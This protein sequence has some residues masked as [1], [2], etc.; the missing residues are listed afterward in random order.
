[1]ITIFT[2][3]AAARRGKE[4]DEAI[5]IRIAIMDPFRNLAASD[6]RASN[7]WPPLQPS[8][9][10]GGGPAGLIFRALDTEAADSILAGMF[11]GSRMDLPLN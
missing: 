6:V 7:V 8:L 3:E 4:N 2:V 5:K 9:L 10:S 11:F 1:L